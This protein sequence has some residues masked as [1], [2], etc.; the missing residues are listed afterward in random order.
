VERFKATD[1]E[2][3]VDVMPFECGGDLTNVDAW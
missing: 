2:Q 3:T 1:D